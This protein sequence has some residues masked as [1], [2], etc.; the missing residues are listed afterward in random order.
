MTSKRP[1][2][3]KKI[4]AKDFQ[5]FY[6][7]KEELVAFCREVGINVWLKLIGDRVNIIVLT[8]MG[9]IYCGTVYNKWGEKV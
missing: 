3:N 2:L 9:I 8:I 5:D 7:M 4:N 6:W 1:K